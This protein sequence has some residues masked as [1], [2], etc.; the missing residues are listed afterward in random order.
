[1]KITEELKPEIQGRKVSLSENPYLGIVERELEKTFSESKG[2]IQEMCRYVLDAG[3]KR[4]RPLLVINSGLIFSAQLD[5]LMRAAVAAEL[6]HMA[7]LV[8]DDIID[9]A[10][11]RRNRPSVKQVWGNHEAVLCGDYLFAK[12]FA[13]LAHHRLNT[14]LDLMVEAIQ[15]MC[16]GEIEQAEDRYQDEISLETYY[17]RITKKTA[18]LLESACQAGAA[19]GGARG[20]PLQAIG[21]YGRNL[22]LAFQIIDDILDFRGDPRQMGKPK[23]EDFVQGHLTL[24]VLLLLEDPKYANWVKEFREKR[25]FSD[26]ALNKLDT[27]L[28]ESGVWKK[29]FEIARFHIE[30]CKKC[31]DLLPSSAARKYL[32][33]LADLLLVRIN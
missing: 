33:E 28:E 18:K 27:V 29:S 9:D 25:D 20:L 10:S 15:S 19:L 17:T 32:E 13:I 4:I 5:L 7:S 16:E 3:G 21:E 26:M 12:A 22:G 23:R 14:C 24:P 6:I 1:M 2:V 30:K 11:F 8:H 31:L